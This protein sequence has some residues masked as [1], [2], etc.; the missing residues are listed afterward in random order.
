M[1]QP[2]TACWWQ[3]QVQLISTAGSMHGIKDY[4]LLC[5]SVSPPYHGVPQAAKQAVRLVDSRCG[6]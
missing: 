1:R 4:Q 6:S 2:R 3:A 5:L